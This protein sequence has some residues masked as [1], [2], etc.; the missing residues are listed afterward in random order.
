MSTRS[1]DLTRTFLVIV[2][3]A[4]LIVGSLWTLLP[5][6]GALMWAT[7]ITV[8]T[9]PLLMKLQDRFGGRRTPAAAIMTLAIVTVFLVPFAWAVTVLL[10]AGVQGVELVREAS[11]RGWQ[12]LPDWVVSLPWVGA[13]LDN[14]WQEL[15]A[16]GPDRVAEALRPLALQAGGWM[17]AMTGGAGVVALH[18]LLTVIIAAMLYS[19]GEQAA[20]GVIAFAERIN[21]DR[22][23]RIVLLAG[24]AVRGVALGV[25]VTALLQSVIAG[26]GLWAASVPRWGILLAVTFVLC[27]AQLGP[28]LVLLPAAAWLAWLDR[29]IAAAALVVL[30]VL[31]AIMENVVKPVLIRRGVDLPM[32]LLIAGVLGGLVAFGIGGLFIG[33][34]ILAVTYTLLQDWIRE[35]E[36][37]PSV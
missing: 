11:Q 13:R 30:T 14:R 1:P 35:R 36:E 9:W 18:F 17:I 2:I 32:L 34:V 22:G 19:K 7:T 37:D 16:G 28:L 8:A 20:A 26:L 21:P 10:D 24:Q 23:E 31:I 6:L 5:F 33:P 12:P 25:I 3:I 15:A 29:P 27:I 4:C